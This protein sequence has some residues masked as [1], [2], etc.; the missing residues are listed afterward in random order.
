MVR[1]RE[2]C[3]ATTMT[4]G[5]RRFGQGASNLSVCLYKMTVIVLWARSYINEDLTQDQT[6]YYELSAK[7]QISPAPA[8][9]MLRFPQEPLRTQRLRE[10]PAL[11]ERGILAKA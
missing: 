5:P 8:K 9:A 2:P 10:N 4:I 6:L 3:S 7:I 1:G 11:P